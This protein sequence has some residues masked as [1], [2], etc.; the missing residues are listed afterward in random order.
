MQILCPAC[1][2][3]AVSAAVP[4]C[5]RCGCDLSMLRDIRLAA[6]ALLRE[7]KFALADGDGQDALAYAT[8]SW[9]L[10]H[11]AVTANVACLAAAVLGDSALLAR[12]R[13]RLN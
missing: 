1:G 7:A 9:T 12:W 8:R 3:I 4:T 6:N 2:K 11:S 13:R 5:D 10:V